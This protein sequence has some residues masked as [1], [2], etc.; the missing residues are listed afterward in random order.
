[1]TGWLKLHRKLLSSEIWDANPHVLKLWIWCLI[2]A[3]WLE[4][5]AGRITASERTAAKECGITRKQVRIGITTLERM[6]MISTH[7]TPKHSTQWKIIK[8]EQH[9]SQS[10]EGP[11][12]SPVA[13]RAHR[14]SG[15][16]MEQK[17]PSLGPRKG[18]SL[19]P[20]TSP[21]TPRA[22]AES[23]TSLGPS[24]GTRK[25]PILK[26]KQ[27]GKEINNLNSEISPYLHSLKKIEQ[28]APLWE[29]YQH[30]VDEQ[31]TLIREGRFKNEGNAWHTKHAKILQWH[32]DR[33]R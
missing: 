16:Q 23:G 13:P 29:Q 15:A 33:T 31:T 32:Q 30:A 4:E 9:Q 24:L 18:P 27:E 7:K 8:W 17:G 1:M 25:G 10:K 21:V 2:K 14:E 5:S 28:E 20:S 12:T 26:E 3:E 11:S 6:G 22:S 19:G